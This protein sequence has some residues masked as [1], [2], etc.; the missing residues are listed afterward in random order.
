[1]LDPHE[2][3]CMSGPLF[4]MGY[5][6]CMLS[7]FGQC[8]TLRDPVDGNTPRF[9]VPRILQARILEWVA[10][11][12]SRKS[13]W[14]RNRTE[15]FRSPALACELF[16]TS[17]TLKH[18]LSW[19][20]ATQNSGFYLGYFRS[21]S[22]SRFCMVSWASTLHHCPKFVSVHFPSLPAEGTGLSKKLVWFFLVWKN[23]EELFGQPNYNFTFH[24][25]FQ[26]TAFLLW[27]WFCKFSIK[28]TSASA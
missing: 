2:V 19:I 24:I 3:F 22:N 8:L 17:A 26:G 20:L 10:V 12:S 21:G 5:L 25:S 14:P 7:R 13:S 6:A 4:P 28:P 23:Q 18:R 16:T 27:D 1:M 15:S 11:P 9:S